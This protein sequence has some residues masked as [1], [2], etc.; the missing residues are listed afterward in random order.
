MPSLSLPAAIWIPSNDASGFASAQMQVKQSSDTVPSPRWLEWLFDAAADEHIV[1]AFTLPQNYAS[2]PVLKIQFKMTS[3]TSGAV[4]WVCKV[5]ALTPADASDMDAETW[6]AA[7][8]VSETVP[9]TAGYLDEASITLTNFDSGA[10][11]DIC[12]MML[13][14]DG[15]GTEVTDS[16]TGDAEFIGADFR[17]S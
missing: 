10:A 9:A 4:G 8:T 14:R 16:A 2:A 3:A 6:A 17:Y 5:M 11:G 13:Y 12:V 1:C 7:N 15:D